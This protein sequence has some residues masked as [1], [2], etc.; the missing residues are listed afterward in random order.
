MLLYLPRTRRREALPVKGVLFALKRGECRIGHLHTT[1]GTIAYIRNTLREHTQ[2]GTWPSFAGPA[3][4]GRV[5]IPGRRHPAP[6]AV[7]ARSAPRV[8]PLLAGDW[9]LPARSCS[10]DRVL[11]QGESRL[12]AVKSLLAARLGSPV[13]VLRR[14]QLRARLP[15]RASWHAPDPLDAGEA[16]L[17]VDPV[18]TRL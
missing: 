5:R 10:V 18:S 7:T 1:K 17:V 13:W 9:T 2:A 11:R 16:Y 3:L 6:F 8:R 14:V 4:E 12:R 15:F